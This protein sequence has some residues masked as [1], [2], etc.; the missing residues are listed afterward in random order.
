MKRK[1]KKS[2]IKL[3]LRVV[4]ICILSYF[5]LNL[6]SYGNKIQKL[7]RQENQLSSELANLK[8]EEEKLKTE[9]LKL[10]DKEYIARYAREHY[11]YSKD[12]EYVIRIDEAKKVEEKVNEK[13]NSR[14]L[15][16]ISGSA[17][18]IIIIIFIKNTKRSKRR[19][20]KKK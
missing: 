8:S 5:S 13:E 2:V 9:I 1:V 15:Y 3:A 16:I 6:I 12:G 18:I 7:K 14:V 4:S 11:L 19:K 10:N 17:L 20:Q